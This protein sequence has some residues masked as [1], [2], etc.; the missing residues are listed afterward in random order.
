ML[1]HTNMLFYENSSSYQFEVD[2]ILIQSAVSFIT[3]SSIP[4]SREV[5]K[6]PRENMVPAVNL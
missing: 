3:R 4:V 5:I 2:F 6:F 1:C